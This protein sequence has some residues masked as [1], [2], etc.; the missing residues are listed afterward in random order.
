MSTVVVLVEGVK[1]LEVE[2]EVNGNLKTYEQ[3][4]YEAQVLSL[5][6]QT[7]ATPLQWRFVLLFTKVE[8]LGPPE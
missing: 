6:A 8:L 2:Q 5:T 7:N 4:G 1:K 3:Q